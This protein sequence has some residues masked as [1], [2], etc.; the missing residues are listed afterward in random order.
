MFS[1]RPGASTL[2][3]GVLPKS[4]RL[5][6]RNTLPSRSDGLLLRN[7]ILDRAVTLV[8]HL[9]QEQGA[10]VVNPTRSLGSIDRRHAKV[11]RE[12]CGIPRQCRR[13]GRYVGVTDGVGAVTV[14]VWACSWTVLSGMM[15]RN[16]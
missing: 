11:F 16:T 6:S 10:P 12:C 4:S 13:S 5:P 1:F 7:P 8:L 2:G 15:M 14:T 9:N 3:A